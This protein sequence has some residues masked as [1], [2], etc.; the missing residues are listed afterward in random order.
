MV[1]RN[2]Q[3]IDSEGRFSIIEALFDIGCYINKPR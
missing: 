3:T 2:G 1:E